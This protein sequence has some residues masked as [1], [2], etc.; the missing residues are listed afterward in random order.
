MRTGQQV[1]AGEIHCNLVRV[2]GKPL[3]MELGDFERNSKTRSILRRVIKAEVPTV[4]CE[5]S[6]M[7]LTCWLYSDHFFVKDISKIESFF[8]FKGGKMEIVGDFLTFFVLNTN[9]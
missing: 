2:L 1:M 5:L 7:G 4:Y 9:S 3:R 6:P 8:R